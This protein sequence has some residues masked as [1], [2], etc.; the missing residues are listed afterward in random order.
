MS[1]PYLRPQTLAEALQARADAPDHALVAGGTDLMVGAL[2]RPE[3]P[4]L[5][6]LFGLAEL[7]GIREAEGKIWIGSG[8]TY[9]ELLAS[10]LILEALPALHACARQVGALQIQQRGT[11]GGNVAT[12]S[13]VGD[14]L[15]VLLAYD[16]RVQ[17]SSVRGAR[18]VPY[19]G[20]CTG[21]RKIDL[22]PDELITAFEFPRPGPDHVAFWRKVGTRKAQAISK[23][24]VAAACVLEGG[25]IRAPRLAMGAVAERP[26][27]LESVEA[28]MAD[29]APSEDLAQE[30]AA[31][32]RGAI[33]PISDLRSSADY[34]LLAAANLAAR[35]VRDLIAKAA[36]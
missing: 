26:L 6:D 23:V 27:R 14:T 35:F 20:F 15:P 9:A 21:Y 36:Q 16:A 10:E 13:P 28:L 18:W 22:A 1:A 31:A 8:T 5:I 4:G 19:H 32:V 24:M 34:R 3:P 2:E 25:T 17:L 33:T 12:S 29:K 11:I 7:K 30:V